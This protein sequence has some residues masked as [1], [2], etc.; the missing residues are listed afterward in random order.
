MSE[1]P[2]ADPFPVAF[3]FII[4][5]LFVTAFIVLMGWVR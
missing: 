5:P 1:E 4:M 3:W 2:K